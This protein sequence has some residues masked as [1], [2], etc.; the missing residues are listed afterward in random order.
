MVALTSFIVNDVPRLF[1]GTVLLSSASR[2]AGSCI[3]VIAKSSSIV[4]TFLSYARD[5]AIRRIDNTVG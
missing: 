2:D 1:V 4:E 3:R 5:M